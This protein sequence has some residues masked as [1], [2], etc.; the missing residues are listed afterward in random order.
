MNSAATRTKPT[1]SRFD[2]EGTVCFVLPRAEQFLRNFYPMNKFIK[3]KVCGGHETKGLPVQFQNEELV[4]QHS[5]TTAVL[6]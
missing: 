4:E 1:S 2:V 3:G 5:L 6:K